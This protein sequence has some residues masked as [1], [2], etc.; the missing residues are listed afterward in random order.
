VTP[1]PSRHTNTSS[2]RRRSETIGI[3]SRAGSSPSKGGAPAPDPL[4]DAR[5]GALER[6]HGASYVAR[7][8]FP[9]ALYLG[10]DIGGTKIALAL[11]DGAG[12][13]HAYERMPTASSGDP[14]ADLRVIVEHCRALLAQHGA[15]IEEV[16]GVGVS[17]PSPLDIEL[18]VVLNPPNLPS[19][20]GTPVRGLLAEALGRP[21]AIENDANAAAL[22]EWR[23][24]AGR[25]CDDLVYLTMSTGVGGGLVLGG[26]IQRGVASSAGEIGH[27]PVEWDGE[28]CSCGLRGCLEAYT[29][30]AAW[31]RR[32]ARL[33]PEGSAV[34]KHAGSISRA[35][36]E[37]VV[38]AAR[39][40]DAFALAELSRYNDYLARGLVAVA[41]VVAPQRIV[42]GTIPT[43]AGEALCLAPVRERF[44]RHVWPFLA[45]RIEIVP[46]ALG[47]RVAAHA[48]IVVAL[49][50][51][52][53]GR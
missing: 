15:R 21:V 49:R 53:G 20:H 36:P 8:G 38:A 27:L 2:E 6:E 23:F 40:G 47:E 50:A 24:G 7:E 4:S 9:I 28:P 19:W 48:G 29:G 25:G 18:G 42:L 26:Q 30:G 1:K 43:A 12:A 51:A 14:R 13:I 35:R 52:E 33:T 22:A 32:L 37:H 3:P 46:S 17:M 16:A 34:A 39:E 5:R 45:E 10:I 31:A 11:G 44:R 41:Y